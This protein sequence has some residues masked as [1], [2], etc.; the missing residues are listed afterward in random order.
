MNEKYNSIVVMLARMS[1]SKD[2][3]VKEFNMGSASKRS[4]LVGRS[5]GDN[6][7]KRNGYDTSV[8]HKSPKIDFPQFCGKS[9]R[10]WVRKANKYFQLHQILEDLRVGIAKMYLKGKSDV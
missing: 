6:R 3:Q 10:E 4:V 2:K 7:T 9:R 5:G 8:N 1:I